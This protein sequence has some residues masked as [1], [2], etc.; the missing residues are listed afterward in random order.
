MRLDKERSA[1]R[2]CGAERD[3]IGANAGGRRLWLAGGRRLARQ[4]RQ[5]LCKRRLAGG[6]LAAAR[7]GDACVWAQ[8]VP[9]FFVT[10]LVTAAVADVL[11]HRY[12]TK[13]LGRALARSA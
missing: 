8:P 6:V 12:Y 1:R 10:M 5:R 7:D 4:C 13:V 3:A 2:P 11:G 9:F